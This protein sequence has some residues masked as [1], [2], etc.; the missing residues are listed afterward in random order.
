M[1]YKSAYDEIEVNVLDFSPSTIWKIRTIYFAQ[2]NR[3]VDSI[4]V[5]PRTW[6]FLINH[7]DY[8]TICALA[9]TEHEYKL[10]QVGAILGI[11]VMERIDMNELDKTV[12]VL[13]FVCHQNLF[14]VTVKGPLKWEELHAG[15]QTNN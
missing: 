15:A 2:E 1:T 6:K 11:P 12:G 4:Q 13:R 5:S 14:A 9:R 8:R 10:G 3:P 7:P